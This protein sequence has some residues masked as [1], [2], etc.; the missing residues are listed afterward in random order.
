VGEGAVRERGG[1]GRGGQVKGGGG[2]RGDGEEL[3][4]HFLLLLC[5]SMP[6]EVEDS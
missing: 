2:D 4:N 1:G 6:C 3:L 5:F